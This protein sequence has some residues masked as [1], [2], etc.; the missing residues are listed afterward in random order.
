MFFVKLNQFK[1]KLRYYGEVLMKNKQK[2]QLK[3]KI[4]SVKLFD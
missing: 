4:N 3:N 2:N 1:K